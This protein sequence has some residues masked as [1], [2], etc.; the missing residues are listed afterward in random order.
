MKKISDRQALSA[1]IGPVIELYIS[2]IHRRKKPYHR[3]CVSKATAAVT[4][5]FGPAG[6][7]LAV[8][9][10]LDMLESE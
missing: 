1:A 7:R 8:R 2:D 9:A 6:H 4:A 5:G 3:S 10:M